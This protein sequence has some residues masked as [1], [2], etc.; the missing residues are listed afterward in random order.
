MFT[1]Y[2]NSVFYSTTK[3]IKIYRVCYL[4]QSYVVLLVK[5]EVENNI[6]IGAIR[7]PELQACNSEKYPQ[8]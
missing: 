4:K 7:G 1:L 5:P 6:V 8:K 2:L 3:N